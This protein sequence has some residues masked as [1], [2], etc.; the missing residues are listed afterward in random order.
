MNTTGYA[1]RIGA[2]SC[3][4]RPH[5]Q[6]RFGRTSIA[7]TLSPMRRW[8][9]PTHCRRRCLPKCGAASPRQTVACRRRTGTGSTTGESK[10]VSSTAVGAGEPESE[11]M[12]LTRRTCCSMATAKRETANISAWVLS[13]TAPTTT[14]WCGRS[15][16]TAAR[17]T[18]CWC[19]ISRPARTACS[20]PKRPVATSPGPLTARPCITPRSTTITA[21]TASGGATARVA[22]AS[23]CTGNPIPGFSCQ[24]ARAARTAS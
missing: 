22:T 9:R 2:R 10:P 4:T 21:P 3:E 8:R 11:P 1:I 15:T 16:A 24:S 18:S 6:S 17:S 19:G 23:W 5:W 14:G 13:S 20:R 12:R 7:K